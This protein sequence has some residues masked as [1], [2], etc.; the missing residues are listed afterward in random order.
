MHL[1][2]S[3]T[4]STSSWPIDQSVSGAGV[5]G[6]MPLVHLVVPRD[7]GDEITHERERLERLDGDRLILRQVIEPGLAHQAR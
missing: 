1:R 4:R 7:V 2:N 6:G 3:A 5:N